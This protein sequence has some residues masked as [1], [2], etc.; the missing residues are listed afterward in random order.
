MLILGQKSCILGTTI[1]KIPQPNWPVGTC[2]TC[3]WPS[4]SP[5]SSIKSV[6]VAWKV[7]KKNGELKEYKSRRNIFI[8]CFNFILKLHTPHCWGLLIFCNLYLQFIAPIN[9]W[10]NCVDLRL[11]SKYLHVP[12]LRP[13]RSNDDQCWILRLRLGNF[14]LFPEILAPNLE[15]VPKFWFIWLCYI[16]FCITYKS[17]VKHEI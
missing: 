3:V 12:F 5:I 1:F 8:V 4:A 17:T 11:F 15:K 9:L 16:S 14:A 7:T 13:L 10:K 6:M 2:W